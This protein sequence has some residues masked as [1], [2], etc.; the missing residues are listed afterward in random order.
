[1]THWCQCQW[2]LAL[3]IDL[4]HATDGDD[5]SKAASMVQAWVTRAAWWLPTDWFDLGRLRR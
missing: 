1:V 5:W 4:R 3:A 2:I